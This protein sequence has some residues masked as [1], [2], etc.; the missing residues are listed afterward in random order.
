MELT[1]V[2]DEMGR[3]SEAKTNLQRSTLKQGRFCFE[4]NGGEDEFGRLWTRL[5]YLVMLQ[6]MSN[7]GDMDGIKKVFTEWEIEIRYEAV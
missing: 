1:K 4:I 5:V 2:I 3:D 6:A 7:L